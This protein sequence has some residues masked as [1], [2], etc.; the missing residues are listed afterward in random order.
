MAKKKEVDSEAKK[1]PE[2]KSRT[3]HT[4]SEGETLADV[5]TMYG[6]SLGNLLKLNNKSDRKAKVGDKF[7][8]E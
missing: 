1:E 7:Y 5:A 4:I 2:V 8:A 6:I 3:V